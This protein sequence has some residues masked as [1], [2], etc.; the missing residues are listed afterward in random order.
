MKYRSFLCLVVVA[1]TVSSCSRENAG[2]G[3]FEAG[4]DAYARG[5]FAAALE[6]WRPLAADGDPASQTNVGF[7]YYEGKGVAQNYEE[8]VRWYTI[9]AKMVYPDALFNLGVAHA[10]GKGV[11]RNPVEAQRWYRLAAEA[12]Y[13]PAQVIMGNI[14]LRGEGVAVDPREG[15]NW[16]MKA[17]EQGDVVAQFLVANLYISGQGV[18]QDLVKAYMWLSVAAT[19]N[20]PDAR[21]NSERGKQL[22]AGRMTP[23]QIA[24]AEKLAEE[25]MAK[26]VN[27]Q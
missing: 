6:I 17:A 27:S 14:Y 20:H 23:M 3:S 9:A 24:E 22:I 25:W 4:M 1:L 8:A 7:L 18:P 2:R 26:R 21:E 10:D 12:G 11:E 16:Y 13:A 19:A 15:M 5:D